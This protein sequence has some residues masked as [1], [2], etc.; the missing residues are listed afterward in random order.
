[1]KRLRHDVSDIDHR[2][3]LT[4]EDTAELQTAV[5]EMQAAVGEMQVGMDELE[6]N[7]TDT[8]LQLC[9]GYVNSTFER[10]SQG[11][12]LQTFLLMFPHHVKRLCCNKIDATVQKI[13]K[14]KSFA[15]FLTRHAELSASIHR[16][17]KR[18]K[19]LENRITSLENKP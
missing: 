11:D 18:I 12:S 2:S 6:T 17:N 3:V 16:Q 7:F 9:S 10:C 15:T 19:D 5:G 8:V 13:T 1:M 4:A 14:T